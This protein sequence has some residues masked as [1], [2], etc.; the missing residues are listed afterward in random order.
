MAEGPGEVTITRYRAHFSGPTAGWLDLGWR[1]LET[2]ELAGPDVFEASFRTESGQTLL[3]RLHTP[4]AS[5][6]FALAA[7]TAF[8]AHPRLLSGDWLPPDFEARCAA[9][10]HPVRPARHQ[11]V[12]G[13]GH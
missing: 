12:A 8:P 11:L 7:A 5:L 9:L 3:S 6:M 10:G 1:A 4:W 13:Q 2:V